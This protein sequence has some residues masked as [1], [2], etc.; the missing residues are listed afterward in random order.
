[1]EIRKCSTRLARL[2]LVIP[3]MRHATLTFSCWLREV[4]RLV[5]SSTPSSTQ[6]CLQKRVLSTWLFLVA[7]NWCSTLV[8]PSQSY[9]CTA[10]AWCFSNLLWFTDSVG[11]H[12]MIKPPV[13]KCLSQTNTYWR[14]WPNSCHPLCRW[15]EATKVSLPVC[16]FLKKRTKL[17]TDLLTVCFENAISA[18]FTLFISFIYLF[19]H[20]NHKQVICEFVM[21]GSSEMVHSQEARDKNLT[22]GRISCAFIWIQFLPNKYCV[23]FASKSFIGGVVYVLL[24]FCKACDGQ[25]SLPPRKLCPWFQQAIISCVSTGRQRSLN[26]YTSAAAFNNEW[27]KLGAQ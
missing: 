2:G 1:M 27:L 17:E 11:T 4:N 16:S 24:F 6:Y 22:L 3:L 8:E 23:I 21:Y 10:P 18:V 14:N 25:A 15:P 9:Y 26:Y 20:P 13:I 7:N 5:F 19:S 12:V